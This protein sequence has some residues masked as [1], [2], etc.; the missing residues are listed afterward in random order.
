MGDQ[1]TNQT[2]PVP[3]QAAQPQAEAQASAVIHVIPEQFYGAALKTKINPESTEG[4]PQASGGKSKLAIIIGVLLL[5]ILVGGAGAFVYFNRDALFGKPTPPPVVAVQPTTTKPTPPPPPPPP[6]APSNLTATST[7]PQSVSL[8]WTDAADSE[9]GYRV[10]RRTGDRTIYERITDLPPNSTNF[11]D[12]SVQAS[13]T[14]YYRVIA[15]NDTGESEPSNEAVAVT[16]PL[17]PPPPK[18]EPLPPAGLD[19]DSD[20]ITDL[21]ENLFGADA[22]NPDSDGDGF[23][24]GNEVFNLYSPVGK[25]PAKLLESGLVKEINGSIGWSMLIPTKW[26]V[27][28]DAPDGSAAAIDSGHG[29]KFLISVE[30]NENNLPVADWYLAKYPGTDKSTLMQYRSK[31]GYEGII[32]PD[33]LTTYIPWGNRIFVFKYDMGKQPFINFRTVYSM[34]LNSLALK[35]LPQ[36]MVPAGTGQLPFEPAATQPGA[37]TQPVSITSATPTVSGTNATSST[38]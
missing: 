8:S 32:G 36:E 10:E 26:T 22:R 28:M 6:N 35:G 17:P 14:Y 1:I 25:A 7:S 21:E 9:T 18:Q 30:K 11:Q 31:G 27:S 2:Q 20:G 24:D 37:I 29:E 23:L 33:L 19:T 4:A 15:R 5:I 34:M 38:P 13:S 16:R 3:V 12:G